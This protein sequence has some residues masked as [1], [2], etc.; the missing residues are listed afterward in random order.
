MFNPK[1]NLLDQQLA[2][3]GLEMQIAGVAAGISAVASIAG[4]IFGSSQASKANAQAQANYQAQK[5]AAKKAAAATNKYNQEVFEADKKNYANSSAYDWETTL[6]NYKY[7]QD[8]QEFNYAQTV[9]QYLGSVENAEQQ[10]IYNAAAAKTAY[11]SEQA[12]LGEIMSEDAFARES[13][14][15]NQLQAQGQ[16]QLM[17]AGKSRAKAMQSISAKVGRD[18]QVMNASLESAALQNQRNMADIALGKF[19]DDQNVINSM[20][21]EPE[22]G[23]ALPKPIQPPKKIFVEPMKATA[24][25]IPAPLMQSTFAPLVSGIGGAANTIMKA[26]MGGAFG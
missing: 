6:K 13:L 14:L 16:A 22:K 23:P 17:Q 18:T 15:V 11:E 1:E 12:S 5:K 3:S 21:I 25:Y 7:N 2:V 10:L 24:A 20:M 4:G 8:I 19:L 26:K 9:K